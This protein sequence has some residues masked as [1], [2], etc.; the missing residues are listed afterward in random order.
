MGINLTSTRTR[1][2][3]IAACVSAPFLISLAARKPA[4]QI[5]NASE[6]N[7]F[8]DAWNAATTSTV[9]KTNQPVEPRPVRVIPIEP[10]PVMIPTVMTEDV[11]IAKPKH[12]EVRRE[13]N[14]CERHGMRKVSIRHGRSWRCRRHR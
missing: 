5:V 8:D 13:R 11:V 1:F 7:R 6:V 3:I 14:V 12:R 2:I 9:F 4:A 10:Q